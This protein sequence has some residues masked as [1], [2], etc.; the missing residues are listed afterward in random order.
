MGLRRSQHMLEG[1]P[2]W[3]RAGNQAVALRAG[4]SL[5]RILPKD[6]ISYM[7]MRSAPGMWP[8]VRGRGSSR[9]M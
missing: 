4:R 6:A 7:V 2:A 3:E 1:A 8:G 9:E 5:R